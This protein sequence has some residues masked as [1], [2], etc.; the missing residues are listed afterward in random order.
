MAVSSREGHGALGCTGPEAQR[1]R[2]GWL[3]PCVLRASCLCSDHNPSGAPGYISKP[4]LA[5]QQTHAVPWQRVPS[6]PKTLD[7]SPLG[8]EPRPGSQVSRARWEQGSQTGAGSHRTLSPTPL[9]GTHTL[10]LPT[11]THTDT[12]LHACTHLHTCTHAHAQRRAHLHTCTHAHAHAHLCAHL[13]T[14]T[15][16]HTHICSHPHTGTHLHTCTHAHMLT[17]TYRCTPAYMYTCSHPHTCTQSCTH[18]HTSMHTQ[19]ETGTTMDGTRTAAAGG[20]GPASW[21]PSR[22]LGAPRNETK[23]C[24]LEREPEGV[25]VSAGEGAQAW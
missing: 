9:I 5:F 13:H 12:H 18:T 2:V 23:D 3:A 20:S 14:C 22:S 6:G 24:W 1:H 16:V 19:M 4:S 11:P 21:A 10:S 15:H 8:T 25:A 7:Q 17:P